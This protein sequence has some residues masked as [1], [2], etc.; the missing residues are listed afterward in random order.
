MTFPHPLNSLL[1]VSLPDHGQIAEIYILSQ[2]F[3]VQVLAVEPPTVSLLRNN[4]T[5]D[6]PASIIILTQPKNSTAEAI[7][8]MDFV[9]LWGEADSWW[10]QSPS[11]SKPLASRQCLEWGM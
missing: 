9:S 7:V 5:L 4:F 6:I 8:S 10:I 3:I 2:P 11:C 1:S